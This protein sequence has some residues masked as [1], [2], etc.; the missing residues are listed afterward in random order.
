LYCD[1][2]KLTSLPVSLTKLNKLRHLVC[3][4]IDN[5]SPDVRRWL[6]ISNIIDDDE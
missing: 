3:D 1:G 4:K 2:N 5:I 6:N